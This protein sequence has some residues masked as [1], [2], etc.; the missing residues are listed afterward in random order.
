MS[1]EDIGRLTAL[2]R[3]RRLSAGVLNIL[4]AGFGSV[5]RLW[6]ASAPELAA[7]GLTPEESC[8]LHACLRTASPE[9]EL[10]LLYKERV[11]AIAD[12][13]PAYPPLLKETAD[14]PPVLFLRGDPRALGREPALAVVGT[15]KMTAYGQTACRLICR[16]AAE[17]GACIVSGLALGLD[18]AAHETALAA[19]GVTVAVLGSGPDRA[20]V[21]PRT[22]CRLAESLI[23]AGG[24]LV[25]EYPPGTPPHKMSFPMRNR[26]IAGLCRAVLVIEAAA[27]S[28]ALITAAAALNYGR[29]VLAVPG[30]ITSPASAGTN[31][32][33][34]QGAAPALSAEQVLAVLGIGPRPAA[35][36]DD[37]P[38]LRALRDG[39]LTIDEI[40][41]NTGWRAGAVMAAVSSLEIAGR[42]A[43]NSDGTAARFDS[44]DQ[45]RLP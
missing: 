27:R 35:A 25:S 12:A 11:S 28:G 20:S 16:P 38:V 31:D 30:P 7:A 17:A 42:L 37:D 23:A 8:R 14:R 9:R 26:I 33:I 43:R 3:Y 15:R 44:P 22:N 4:L 18:A 10:T 5:G 36:P 19:G 13:D 34:R 40:A 2:V 41:L 45:R 39:P 6:A 21:A 1:E 32:L 29:E 24:A